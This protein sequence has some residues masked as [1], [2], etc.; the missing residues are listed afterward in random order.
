[1]RIAIYGS[2]GVGGYYG[3]RLAAAGEDV[4]FIARGAHYEAIRAGGLR[5]KSR[6]G[7]LHITPAQV[8]DDPAVIGPV[9]VIMVAVKLYDTAQA[10]EGCKALIGPETAVVSFQNG[11]TA[12]DTLKTAVG[13]ERVWGGTTYIMAEVAEPGLVVHTG[14]NARL[15][16]GE[17]DG[18]VT[19]RVQVFYAVCTK[20]GIDTVLST[21][22]L[23]DIWTKFS[24]LA[25][26]SGTTA[27][28]RQP[29]GRIRRDPDTRSLFQRAVE[30][31]VAVARAKGIAMKD[32]M[33]AHNM[34]QIDNLPESM[35]SSQ[36]HDLLHGKRLELPWLSGAV[37]RLG[38]EVEIATPVHDFISAA[39]K[40]HARGT[41]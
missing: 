12:A 2:G 4:R 13:A 20:A 38:R 31:V 28:T 26:L 37:R 34:K 24:F 25:A 33:V 17:L 11:V 30:E 29:I 7:D 10:A 9:E 5:V 35:S 40:L 21:K 36:L 16:F 32:D 18:C 39:L 19:P 15:V 14:S 41:A 8:T 1:M 6:N 27:L 23:L 22:I 3:A